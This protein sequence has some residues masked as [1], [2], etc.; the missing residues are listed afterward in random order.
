VAEYDNVGHPY[1]AVLFL[2]RRSPSVLLC[3][4]KIL[5]KAF[6]RSLRCRVSSHYQAPLSSDFEDQPSAPWNRLAA[7]TGTPVQTIA[8]GKVTFAGYKGGDVTW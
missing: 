7:P 8:D 4:W 2:D 6:L 5:A 3:R 1:K